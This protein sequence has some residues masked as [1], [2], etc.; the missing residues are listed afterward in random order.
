MN[1]QSARATILIVDDMPIN[2]KFL[3]EALKADYH[4]RFA[5]S[6]KKGLEIAH[7]PKPP[8]LILLDIVMP[9]LNGYEVCQRL[10]A[11]PQ[12]FN[13]PVIFITS[14]NQEE[15][16][17]KG[18]ACGAVDY[19][20][21]PF[22]V[23]IV[24]MRIKTHLELKRHR[25]ALEK[26]CMVDGLTGIYNR[27]RFDEY[28]TV[29]WKRAERDGS[30]LSLSMI[31][32]DF[33]KIY[34]DTYGHQIGDDC[35]KQVASIL[36]ASVKRP[37]DLVAR[38]GGEEFAGVLPGT[39]MRGAAFVCENMRMKLTEA[40]IPH[41]H[42]PVTP[43]VTISQGAACIQPAHGNSPA[44]LLQM[45]DK[46]LYLAKKEGRNRIKYVDLTVNT[47]FVVV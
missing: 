14:M 32:I 43:Y 12:T 8:D 22:S 13:I 5:T 25:D 6:G 41:L 33:F 30:F 42:S 35:L 7:S 47:E 27:R 31:D 4:V 11:N 39:D 40:Q 37:A 36:A 15:D 44:Y 1:D 2:I 38:Y 24:K 3:G 21:K 19:I 20:T 10:K 29:E 9:G 28:L 46:A 17:T 34:N 45:A 26:L 23:P 18:L 16:E